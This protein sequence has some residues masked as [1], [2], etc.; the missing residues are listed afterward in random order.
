MVNFGKYALVNSKRKSADGDHQPP[1]RVRV[2]VDPSWLPLLRQVTSA[3]TLDMCE[4]LQRRTNALGTLETRGSFST[5]FG[6]CLRGK[7]CHPADLHFVPHGSRYVCF[8]V[9]AI[10]SC[11][12]TDISPDRKATTKIL[13]GIRMG[14]NHHCF[15]K[16]LLL[17]VH[18]HRLCVRVYEKRGLRYT[19]QQWITPADPIYMG[20]CNERTLHATVETQPVLAVLYRAGGCQG[21]L[22]VHMDMSTKRKQIF[23]CLST[24]SVRCRLDT[25]HPF[26]IYYAG[27]PP[28]SDMHPAPAIPINCSSS[29]DNDFLESVGARVSIDFCVKTND[30]HIDRMGSEDRPR[31]LHLQT[32][33]QLGVVRTEGQ[34]PLVRYVLGTDH[35]PAGCTELVTRIL[36]HPPST[37]RATILRELVRSTHDHRGGGMTIP[38]TMR[39][40]RVVA[41]SRRRQGTVYTQ[42]GVLQ[43]MRQHIRGVLT[44][45]DEQPDVV[46]E[47]L[48]LQ[49]HMCTTDTDI[50]D[51]KVDR[52]LRTMRSDADV[53]DA[54]LPDGAADPVS[55]VDAKIKGEFVAANEHRFRGRVHPRVYG[56]TSE[57]EACVAT[58]NRVVQEA[59]E[60]VHRVVYDKESRTLCPDSLSGSACTGIA[61]ELAS[62]C[63]RYTHECDRLVA[64]VERAYKETLECVVDAH[65]WSHHT[66][67][68]LACVVN[69]VYLHT[70]H[71]MRGQQ[72]TLTRESPGRALRIH[73]VWPFWMDMARSTP[74]HIDMDGLIMLTGPNMSGKSTLIRS[75]GACVLLGTCGFAVPARDMVL[76][77]YSMVYVRSSSDDCPLRNMS[78]FELEMSDVAS[79][80]REM[81]GVDEARVPFVCIDEV[82]KGT[83][84]REC[85]ATVTAVFEDMQSRGYHGVFSTHMHDAIREQWPAYTIAQDT[86]VLR[87]GVCAMSLARNAM[88][89]HGMPARVIER[90]DAC[91]D[92]RGPAPAPTEHQESTVGSWLRNVREGAVDGVFINAHASMDAASFF[93]SSGCVRVDASVLAEM[94]RV[95]VRVVVEDGKCVARG[96]GSFLSV[97]RGVL[98]DTMG[99]SGDLL[100]VEHHEHAP[101]ALCGTSVL[102]VNEHT[103]ANGTREYYVG[104]SDGFAGRMRAHKTKHPSVRHRF[105][106]LPVRTKNIAKYTETALIRWCSER[107]SVLLRSFGDV[108]HSQFG[109]STAHT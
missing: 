28:R 102:Y 38:E 94:G 7:E 62:L 51:D 74:N 8:G 26:R 78:C 3:D 88:T 13:S 29:V 54:M 15:Q 56:D 77:A 16:K 71:A 39:I 83:S 11:H 45:H 100:V 2:G 42:P 76:P 18:R 34:H 60:N 44:L 90:Y 24:E 58:I 92:A 86:H 85:K 59:G 101:P 33:R 89:K 36:T 53:L 21:H 67:A 37:A 61:G 66:S 31:P 30:F 108:H 104:E 73:G 17:L 12:Y 109:R 96:V 46:R 6:V 1:K 47:A 68:E 23:S 84:T 40:R 57:L 97:L 98:F 27:V 20:I 81:D 65:M 48:R 106:A 75:V 103:H 41:L 9:D 55:T 19:C 22:L 70:T 4:A 93:G 25:A 87:K 52:F 49:R 107:S 63:A 5:V 82:G 64:A 69:V 99:L 91:M 32:A 95:G 105:Y 72:W 50:D 43:M 14:I 10:V 35:P 79:V 80:Y